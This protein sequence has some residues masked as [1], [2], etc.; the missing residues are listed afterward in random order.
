MK[1]RDHRVYIKPKDSDR[2]LDQVIGRRSGKV[3]KL[4]FERAKALVSSSSSQGE[5][6]HR[7]MAHLHHGA[8]KHLR[9]AVI[10]FLRYRRKSIT[11][12]RVVLW[13][14]TSRSLSHIVSTSPRSP[15]TWCIQMY[16]DL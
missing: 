2:S 3:Y 13:G 7:R 4:H 16:V 15:W 6:W 11:T 5:L 10:E 1:F 9:Q 8:M 14:R 12:T